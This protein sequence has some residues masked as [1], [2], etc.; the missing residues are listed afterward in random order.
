MDTEYPTMSKY[1]TPEECRAAR[2]IYF[3]RR[4][5]EFQAIYDLIESLDLWQEMDEVYENDFGWVKRD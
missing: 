1:L 5:R 2:D 3:K 4:K